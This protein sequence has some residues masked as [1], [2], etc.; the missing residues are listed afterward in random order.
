MLAMNKKC[1]YALFRKSE[2]ART[3]IVALHNFLSLITVI[4][5][6]CMSSIDA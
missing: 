1:G 2:V 5:S 6:P 3:Q 4:F